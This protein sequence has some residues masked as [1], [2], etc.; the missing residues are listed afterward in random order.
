VLGLARPLRRRGK[1]CFCTSGSRAI[2][3][4]ASI[5]RAQRRDQVSDKRTRLRAVAD[6]ADK[7]SASFGIE[8]S[9]YDP[10]IEP[11]SPR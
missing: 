10:T 11:G 2:V 7:V 9:Y 6:L 4:C 8:T 1:R 5:N 3:V